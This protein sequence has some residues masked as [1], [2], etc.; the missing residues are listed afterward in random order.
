MYIHYTTD[1]MAN[2]IL[3]AHMY[4]MDFA[5]GN[6][7]HGCHKKDAKCRFS[8]N[9]TAPLPGFDKGGPNKVTVLICTDASKTFEPEGEEKKKKCKF[10]KELEGKTVCLKNQPM[11]GV[12]D[13][14]CLFSRIFIPVQINGDTISCK[15]CANQFSSYEPLMSALM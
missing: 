9:A 6:S 14:D 4:R 5:A 2:T 7:V 3:C 15:T 13:S 8:K 1:S 12:S 10:V 11:G